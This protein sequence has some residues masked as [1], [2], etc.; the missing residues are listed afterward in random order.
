MMSG[1]ATAW[2]EPKGHPKG[3]KTGDL[4]YNFQLPTIQIPTVGSVDPAGNVWVANIWNDFDVASGIAP[5]AR[6][7]TWGGGSGFTIIYG[8]A[9][10][11][12]TPLMG[13]VRKP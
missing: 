10:P 13:Q 12:K 3:T 4:I 5:S 7:S 11:V 9:A 2:A 6:K 8:V 1:S